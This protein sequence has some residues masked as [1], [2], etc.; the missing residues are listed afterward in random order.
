MWPDGF[1]TLP[2]F[3]SIFM[4]NHTRFLLVS[5]FAFCVMAVSVPASAQKLSAAAKKQL[6]LKED[7]L[8]IISRKM[9][10][11]ENAAERFRSD[12]IFVRT[13]IRALLVPNSFYYSFDSLNVSKVYAP[14]SSFRIFTWQMKKDEY[15]IMQK[16]AIQMNTPDGSLKLFPL[17]DYSMFTPK[18]DDSVRTRQNWIGAI[19][20]KAIMKE[21]Q[22]K[23]YYTLI[24][25][26]DFSI[27]SNKKWMEVLHF[28]AAGEPVFGGPFIS[29]KEDSLKKPT[30]NRF[31]I[32]YK[33]EAKTYF[34]YDPELD[35]IIVDHLVSETDEP[36][37]KFTY[38]PDGDYEAFRWKDGQWVH[39]D[40]LFN[41]QLKDGDFPREQL[42]FDDEGNA[43]ERKL[44]EASRKN[45]ENSEKKTPPKKTTTPPKKKT[46]GN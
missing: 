1:V 30:L 18:P 27:N 40:K 45:V 16:G 29:F 23:K 22:G 5:L 38:V 6:A 11:S 46:G 43:D 12:S 15:V 17:F 35:L 25:F 2:P 31:S 3:Q 19:Y 28:N 33:K 20:Y 14:D 4:I 42:L 36:E 34:N 10:F 7:S 39:I 37:K 24:G 9:V 44:E 32:Q 26:D 41:Q 21:Y 13:L 8:A